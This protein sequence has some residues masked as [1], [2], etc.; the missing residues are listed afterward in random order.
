MATVAAEEDH[1]AF[2]FL[3]SKSDPGTSGEVVPD[4]GAG[5]GVLGIDSKGRPKLPRGA[6]VEDGEVE[7]LGLPPIGF[8]PIAA[9]AISEEVR[10][11]SQTG[12]TS[13]LR[14]SS[15]IDWNQ[16]G[17]LKGYWSP[18]FAPRESKLGLARSLFLRG[19]LSV[20]CTCLSTTLPC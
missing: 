11:Y 8:K 20:C 7:E 6:L 12:R 16:V 18:G 5:G 4:A 1:A 2:L 17:S 9:S 14:E 15:Q 10:S 13:M 3:T 19:M